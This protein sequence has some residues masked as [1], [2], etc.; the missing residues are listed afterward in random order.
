MA[1][2]DSIERVFGILGLLEGGAW[3][4]RRDLAGRLGV[5]SRTVRR[6]LDVMCRHYAVEERR[7]GNDVWCRLEPSRRPSGLPLGEAEALS[8]WMARP[9]MAPV[10][11]PTVLAAYDSALAKLERSFPAKVRP[12]LEA[13]SR[14]VRP[15]LIPGMSP[16][17]G[18]VF[19][20]LLRAAVGKRVTRIVYAAA[21]TGN[22][23]ER[24]IEPLVVWQDGSGPRVTAFCRR[25][26][27]LRDFV[28]ARVRSIDVT[29]AQ[30][31]AR[32]GI[33]VEAHITG[34]FGGL[35]GDPVD[36]QVLVR[37]PSA[38]WARDRKAH[39]TQRVVEVAGGILVTF[40][41]GGEEAIARW[42]L[43][44]GHDA[45]V[46][47]PPSVAARVR[48]EA[49]AVAARYARGGRR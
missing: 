17:E 19:E 3:I 30:F 46:L 34:A 2:G 23:K 47:S 42:V 43:S 44:L 12:L 45:L 18:R 26:H 4:S 38:R 21:S 5:S 16:G 9:A 14:T 22:V 35:H 20:A 31:Q 15:H 6:D 10:V 41:A 25:E 1:R 8:L 32:D 39:P 28:L 37:D 24:E 40:R 13:V 48:K 36:V 33:D 7:E 29:T 27:K 49:L 11:P